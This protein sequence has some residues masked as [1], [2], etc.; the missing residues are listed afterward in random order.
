MSTVIYL[1]NQQI[2]I[3]EGKRGKAATTINRYI[4]YPAPQGT[5]IN[6]IIMDPEA[7]GTFLKEKWTE[8][9]LPVKDVS[10]VVNSTK[11]VGQNMEIPKM[12]DEKTLDHIKRGFSNIDRSEERVYGFIRLE[13]SHKKMQRLYAESVSPDYIS[14]Y[15]KFFDGIGI[16]LKGIYSGEGSMI[17]LVNAT[18]AKT[19]NTFMLMIADSMTLTTVLYVNKVFTYYNS[20]RCFHEPGTED[21]AQDLTRSASQIKQFMQANQ[22]DSELEV[23][24]LAGVEERDLTFYKTIMQ[25]YGVQTKIDIFSDTKAIKGQDGIFAQKYLFATSGLF[26]KGLGGNYITRYQSK[27]VEKKD[28]SNIKYFVIL[29]LTLFVMGIV[30]LLAFLHR[31]NKQK[32]LE[33]LEDY[34]NDPAILMQVEEF[35]TL[36]V[37]NNFLVGQYLSIASINE[38]LDTYPWATS[39]LQKKI[40]KLAKGYATVTITSCDA[41]S[42]TTNMSVMAENPQVINEFITI[43][44]NQDIFHSVTY[45]GYT[46]TSEKLYQVN[47][48]CV[49]EEAVGRSGEEDEG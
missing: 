3:V 15:I 24:L 44:M 12:Q 8:N 38:N 26:E 22:L 20:V 46:Y 7:F 23:I 34:N 47:V 19:Y 14:D 28:T 33:A 21:Y 6:G 48:S 11:F 5:I 40:F 30:F 2:H 36:T 4:S 1:S 13:S 32:E 45:S 9:K 29:A 17:S 16:K 18:A 35:D 42:G 27:K 49:L 25:E 39:K 37:R 41:N 43:L 31:R 10:L